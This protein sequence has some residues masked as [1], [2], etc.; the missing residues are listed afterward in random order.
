[1]TGPEPLVVDVDTDQG[2]GRLLIGEAERPRA[3]LVLGHGAGGGVDGIDLVT[4]AA[5]LPARGITVARYV[6]PWKVAGRRIAVRPALLDAAWTPVVRALA[7]SA[8]PVPLVVG[9]H[10]AGARVACRTAAATGA[11][12]VLALSFPLH[13]PG[14]PASSR[15]DELLAAPVPVLVVQGERDPFGSGDEIRAALGGAPG[16]VPGVAVVDV[17]A[18]GHDLSPRR[19]PGID[20]AGW[21]ADAASAIADWILATAA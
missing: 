7:A 5:D 18:A 17:P 19:A 16:G 10:S 12:G 9:G 11:Q 21:W 13:P 2:P 14:R 15:L 1:M 3:L 6:Q 20:P 4:L 8:G